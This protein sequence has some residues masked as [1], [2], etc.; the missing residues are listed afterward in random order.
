MRHTDYVGV[1]VLSFAGVAVAG[2]TGGDILV[3]GGGNPGSEAGPV[4]ADLAVIPSPPPDFAGAPPGTDLASPPP[5][6]DLALVVPPDMAVPTLAVGSVV[7]NE[8]H[9]TNLG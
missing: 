7:I 1:L 4:T 8:V 6:A 5:N 3:T 9:A 2:C